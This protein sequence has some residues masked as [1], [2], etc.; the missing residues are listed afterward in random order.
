MTE[1]AKGA[2]DGCSDLL[3]VKGVVQVLLLLL[4]LLILIVSLGM[5]NQDDRFVERLGLAAT[6]VEGVDEL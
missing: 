6:H 3:V 1:L 4:H 5:V 2:T